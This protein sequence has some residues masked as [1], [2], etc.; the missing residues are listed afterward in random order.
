M[1]SPS[2]PRISVLMNSR[3]A[4]EFLVEAIRSVLWQT[5]TSLELI[6]SEGSDDEEGVRIARA[7]DDSR[8]ILLL[9]HERLGWAHGVN[10]GFERCSGDYVAF[11]AGD[12]IMHP[13]CLR[14]M[15]EALDRS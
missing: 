4:P 15:A 7:F 14:K 2:H 9:D 5:E 8:L 1:V 13:E 6:L 3:N 10:V 12:D 11:M